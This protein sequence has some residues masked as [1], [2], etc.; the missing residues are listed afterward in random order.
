MTS[1]FIRRLK[2]WRSR[3]R[4][5]GLMHSPIWPGRSWRV[6]RRMAIEMAPDVE[7]MKAE[8]LADLEREF[9]AI[10]KIPFPS[11]PSVAYDSNGQP[12]VIDASQIVGVKLEGRLAAWRESPL[13]FESPWVA[14]PGYAQ[15]D[16]DAH[17]NQ[18][19]ILKHP[20]DR[21]EGDSE[22]PLTTPRKP[23]TFGE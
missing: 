15:I 22:L 10:P 21:D 3:L 7:R 2:K 18:L 5:E 23:S 11:Y 8:I 6:V 17:I 9:A 12:V 14:G 4:K 1:K 16:P 13:S 19:T 20:L